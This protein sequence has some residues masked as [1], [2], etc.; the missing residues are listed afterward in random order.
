M[1]AGDSLAS[2]GPFFPGGNMLYHTVE[3]SKGT[4]LGVQRGT[5]YLS[6]G[7][8][9]SQNAA[10]SPASHV[11]GLPQMYTMQDRQ[12]D[13]LHAGQAAGWLRQVGKA[14]GCGSMRIAALPLAKAARQ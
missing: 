14:V 1:K 5:R 7:N 9:W 3:I 6:V 8:A 10:Y 12:R 2:Q 11:A 13:V 4:L